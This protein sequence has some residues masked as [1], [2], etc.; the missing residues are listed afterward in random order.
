MYTLV[1]LLLKLLTACV[2]QGSTFGPVLFTLYINDLPEL[3]QPAT[4]QMYADN[5][6]IYQYAK[7]KSQ[8]AKELTTITTSVKNWLNDSCLFLNMDKTVCVR[9]RY[10]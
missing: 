9:I 8:T 7:T 3:C 6:V 2:P 4:C 10:F 5:M 1:T